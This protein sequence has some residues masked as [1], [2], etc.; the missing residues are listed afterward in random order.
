[1]LSEDSAGWSGR[2]NLHTI[3]RYGQPLGVTC[4][5]GRKLAIPLYR[6]GT[7]APFSALPISSRALNSRMPLPP[8]L[9]ANVVIPPVVQ[10][11]Y[12]GAW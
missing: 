7:P 6:L 8:P 12:P 10:L 4:E 3:K 9:P 11:P 2:E 5:C 1:M